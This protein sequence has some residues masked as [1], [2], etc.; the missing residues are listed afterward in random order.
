M[1]IEC[2]EVLAQKKQAF[3]LFFTY[4]VEVST[5][6]YTVNAYI[7]QGNPPSD[8]SIERLVRSLPDES[9]SFHDMDLGERKQNRPIKNPLDKKFQ[10]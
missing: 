5:H 2:S 7:V 9:C 10:I 8:G 6:Q 4:A 1:L 3:K